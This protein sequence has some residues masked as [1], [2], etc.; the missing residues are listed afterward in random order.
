MCHAARQQNGIYLTVQHNGSR[1]D[2]FWL[3]GKSW[4]PTP[5]RHAC[6]LPLSGGQW[7]AHRS[8]PN[9]L[10]ARHDRRY[11]FKFVFCVATGTAKIYQLPGREAYRH[12]PARMGLHR[13]AHYLRRQP[14]HDDG[15]RRRCRHPSGRQ[16]NPALRSAYD[17]RRQAD[18]QWRW[19]SACQIVMRGIRGEP[20]MRAIS[21]SSSTTPGSAMNARQPGS[22]AASSEAMRHPKL[23]A[24]VRMA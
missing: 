5:T 2:A 4:H 3:S 13:R 16:S 19:F 18:G 9:G 20:V 6:P 15:R 14:C 24:W 8:C 21:S 10:S 22:S 23:Q 11:A 7:Q 17:A 1:T 12:V